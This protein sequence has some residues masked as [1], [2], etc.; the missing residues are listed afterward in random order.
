MYTA[1]SPT[2][3]ILPG[4]RSESLVWRR[5]DWRRLPIRQQ[6]SWPDTAALDAVRNR[7]ATLPPLTSVADV[8]RLEVSL[9][10][11]ASGRAFL[12]QAGDCAEPMDAS[13]A[14]AVRG[15]NRLIGAMAEAISDRTGL[16]TVTVGRIGGQFAKPR[17]RPTETVDGRELVA[18]RGEMV[19][20]PRAD[21]RLRTPDPSRLLGA[22][23]ASKAV[24]NELY[25]IAHETAVRRLPDAWPAPFTTGHVDEAGLV[26]SWDGSLRSI[27]GDYGETRRSP[28]GGWAHTGL[29]TS[30]EALILDY[31]EPLVRRDPQTGE[32]FLLSTHMPWI[33][34]RTRR[35]GEA[36]VAFHAGIANPVGCKIG[37]STTPDEVVGLCEALNP[38]RKP[39]RLTLISRMGADAVHDR[40][41][42]LVRAVRAA[43]HPVV[44][45]CDPMHGNTERLPDGRKT[46][47]VARI[48]AEIRG[49]FE[50][51][52]DVG[53]RPGGLHLEVADGDSAECVGEGGPM[54][55]EEIGDGYRTLCDPRLNEKQ[56]IMIADLTG[57][58]LARGGDGGSEQPVPAADE[59]VWTRP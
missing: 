43:E 40:L 3:A 21:E 19:N 49:F 23:R 35:L 14:A 31:E 4:R 54:S 56:S 27:L 52:R 37:P 2:A 55:A 53:E 26:R 18:F 41:P 20:D 51:L 15:K 34:D 11:A 7:L 47:R 38:T 22:Y 42:G 29:W 24:L 39:G 12:L 45:V 32:W 6:P 57:R 30:H 59:A 58:L 13:G 33:G 36:H 25:I 17:S 48:A 50:V 9:A 5:D 10:K 46:R 8:R 16:P 1:A 44:W 28:S